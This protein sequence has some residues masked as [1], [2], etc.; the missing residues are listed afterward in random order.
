MAAGALVFAEFDGL[1]FEPLD[2]AVG[3]EA[4]VLVFEED[5][6][7]LVACEVAAFTDPV[8]TR[9]AITKLIRRRRGMGCSVLK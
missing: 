1:V 2:D 3:L 4:V 6:G 5:A 7:G 9:E 8:A